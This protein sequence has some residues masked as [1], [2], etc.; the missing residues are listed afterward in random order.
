MKTPADYGLV[1]EDVSLKTADGL[2]LQGWYLPGEN[3][4]AIILMHGLGGN[5]ISLLGVAESL[6]EAGY[7]ALIFD[8]RAHGESEG[9]FVPYGGPEAEDVKTA[10]SYL[11][12]RPEVDPERIGSLGWSL[13]A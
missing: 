9:E 11:Q 7:S 1:Y 10:V 4:A 3:G 6:V 5:R 12:T 8:L 2:T 13:G